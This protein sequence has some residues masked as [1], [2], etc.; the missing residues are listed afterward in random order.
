M[1]TPVFVVLTKSE[2][3]RCP[4]QWE[5]DYFAIRDEVLDSTEHQTAV[6]LAADFGMEISPARPFRFIVGDPNKAMAIIAAY[7][8]KDHTKLNKPAIWDDTNLAK[9]HACCSE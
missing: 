2:N 6:E 3:N 8:V 1:S 5:N 7:A 4:L 9:C